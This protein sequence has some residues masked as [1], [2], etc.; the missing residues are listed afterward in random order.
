VK[1]VSYD[2]AREHDLLWGHNQEAMLAIA[3]GTQHVARVRSVDEREAELRARHAD[4]WAARRASTTPGP[5]GDL[6]LLA[7]RLDWADS[8]GIANW[9]RV[10]HDI[11]TDMQGY[12]RPEE[13]AERSDYAFAALVAIW[14]GTLPREEWPAALEARLPA[15]PGNTS[16]ATA[17]AA[18]RV[19]ASRVITRDAELRLVWDATPEGAA[20]LRQWVARLQRALA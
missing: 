5:F 9:I 11:A 15:A 4:E 2:E 18:A 13:A 7:E 10:S 3:R 19:L 17:L 6:A 16:M 12:G 14:R 8:F 20:E 1:I